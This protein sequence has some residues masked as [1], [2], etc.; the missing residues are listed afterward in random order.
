MEIIITNKNSTSSHR[1]IFAFYKKEKK[2]NILDKSSL[3]NRIISSIAKI[4]AY[5]DFFKSPQQTVQL[6]VEKNLFT[7]IGVGESDKFTPETLRKEVAKIVK[8]SLQ[9]YE[10]ISID[11]LNLK[12]SSEKDFL[13]AAIEASHLS[14]Y[15]FEKY[16]GKKTTR[17]LK[18]IILLS[19]VK[20]GQHYAK[21]I[22]NITESI[23]FA[24]DIIN[25]VPNVLTSEMLAKEIVS[26]AKKIKSIKCKVLDKN[27]IKKEKMGL[28]LAVNQGSMHQPRLVHLTYTPKKSNKNTPHLILVGKGLTFDTGGYSLKNSMINMKTDMAGAATVYAAFRSAAL[29]NAD[30]KISCIL[31]ITDNSISS[32]AITP[33]SVVIARNKKSVEI[34]NT[35][36][37]GRLVLA[38]CLDYAKDLKPTAII[39]C[40][41]L[42][43]AVVAALGTEI[44][45]MMSNSDKFSEM[46][47]NSASNCNE[48]LWRLPLIDEHRDDI[49][50]N[51]ADIRNLA[52]TSNAGSMKAA[53]FLEHFIDPKTPWI[54]LDIAGVADSQGH[55]PYCPSKGASGVMVRS[56]VNLIMNAKWQNLA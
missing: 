15:S 19:S 53:A 42:T 5:K 20:N 17:K 6:T 56:L 54:H 1:F 48:Y 21:Q 38:D 14:A 31:G 37:E 44:C 33:D 9:K 3:D 25:D 24:R 40:A 36:A 41:T 16:K 50:S 26:N 30:I 47:L 46:L 34:A 32:K 39:D 10:E 2:Q 13:L 12:G 45:G 43:G 35:D 52:N 29:L 49:K 28:F 11:L 22:H 27:A 55:L 7:V 4:K 51:I 8:S 18:Q 23:Y